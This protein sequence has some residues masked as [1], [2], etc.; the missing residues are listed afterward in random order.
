MAR[1]EH[2]E[3]T[4]FIVLEADFC[5]FQADA[6]SR[7]IWFD[8]CTQETLGFSTLESAAEHIIDAEE[9]Q[10]FLKCVEAWNRGPPPLPSSPAPPAALT[11]M[12]GRRLGKKTAHGAPAHDHL[13]PGAA[14]H[15]TSSFANDPKPHLHETTASQ[16]TKEL[17]DLLAYAKKA[18]EMD[19]GQ[20]IWFG[21]NCD[22]FKI[23]KKC[24]KQ[25][26]QTG[27]QG[28]M[29][30]AKGA[31]FLTARVGEVPDMHMGKWFREWIGFEL[32][33][34]VGS[35]YVNPPIGGFGKHKSTTTPT[36][37]LDS[38]WDSSWSQEG[39]RV[40]KPGDKHRRLGEFTKKGPAVWL[41]DPIVLPC[42]P[43]EY[44][45]RTQGPP[46]IPNDLTGIS[47]WH[48]ENAFCDEEDFIPHFYTSNKQYS[49]LRESFASQKK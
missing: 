16:C 42:P 5:F 6:I 12:L 31:R 33:K 11:A 8:S 23:D 18:A 28:S 1:A 9:R 4:L 25:S 41:T 2:P 13:P 3:D 49:F 46:G 39:T 34:L 36:K 26:P 27:A 29:I 43:D 24:R 7:Q 47:A 48:C 19:R 17:L 44:V 35:C 40:E 21:Y 14:Q 37:Y 10:H 45:W 30:T 15:I 22:H 20:F 32:Q 38:K